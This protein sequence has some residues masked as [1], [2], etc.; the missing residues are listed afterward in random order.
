[1]SHSVDRKFELVVGAKVKL[2]PVG[3]KPGL[4][5]LRGAQL[6]VGGVK[7]VVSLFVYRE[8]EVAGRIKQLG[9]QGGGEMHVN[10]SAANSAV[11]VNGYLIEN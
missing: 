8:A 10:V 1:M 3:Y 9:D 6:I 2:D 5:V 4:D 11:G 7:A